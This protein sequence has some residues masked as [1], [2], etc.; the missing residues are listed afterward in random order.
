MQLD[1]DF[2]SEIRSRIFLIVT[3]TLLSIFIARLIQLQILQ[4]SQYNLRSESQGIKK[5]S[6]E[7]VRGNIFDKFGRLIV[8]NVPS[9][10]I[11]ITPSKLT[12]DSKKLLASIMF[13]DTNEI[14]LKIK[15][16]KQT[17]FSPVRIFRDV[18][19][20]IIIKIN[21]YHRNLIGVDVSE[22]SKRSYLPIVRA[23]HLLGY[24]REINKK[25]IEIDPHYYSFGDIIGKTGIENSYEPFLRGE[26]GYDYI[27]VN[28]RGQR[29]SAFNDGKLDQSAT[30]GFDLYTSLDPNLQTYAESLMRG[31]RGAIV[32]IDPNNGEI[33]TVASAPDYDPLIFNNKSNS[34]DFQQV[35]SDSSKPL[36]NRAT[37]AIYPPGSTWKPLMAIAGMMEGLITP[38][39]RISC[40]GSFSYGGRTWKCHGAHGNINVREAIHVSCNVFFYKLALQLGIDN[41]YKWGKIFRFG[42]KQSD[43]PENKTLLP[44]RE[45]LDKMY[46][47]DKFPRGILVNLG[48]GQGQLG[49][50]VLQLASYISTIANNGVYHQPH[51]VRAIRNKSNNGQIQQMVFENEDLKIPKEFLDVV[52]S[53]LSDVV[54]VAGGTA[55]GVSIKGVR[56]AGKTGTAQA[57]KNKKDH[58]W[59]VCY[60]PFDKPKI[61]IC[62]LVENSGL[63]GRNAA[64]IASRL[65]QFYLNRQVDSLQL[66]TLKLL[67]PGVVNENPNDVEESTMLP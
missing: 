17:P 51:L 52:H 14:N 15:Q 20:E 30:N 67:P 19:F 23:S 47:K 38:K 59:F 40:G 27:A 18:P 24:A 2:G 3:A 55:T 37:Q 32:A 35:Y 6:R 21:E 65:V 28:N 56:L 36:F 45:Y 49:V 12:K 48:I 63:G 9:Y 26:K 57:G 34:K 1:S 54:N 44:S 61:A 31:K 58:A 62:V 43:I 53:G 25:E 4:G 60:A 46:G 8:G 50:S 11:L 33:L 42:T 10:G 66:D 29:V 7:P 39:T 22:D 13:I 5:I 16:Y 41:Y 64:P